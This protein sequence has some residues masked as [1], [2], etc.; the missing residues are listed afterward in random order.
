[1]KF[2]P[3][4]KDS[5][6]VNDLLDKIQPSTPPPHPPRCPVIHLLCFL[7]QITAE[8]PFT[9]VTWVLTALWTPCLGWMNFVWIPS[10]EPVLKCYLLIRNR[11]CN[12][13]LMYLA[14]LRF[15]LNCNEQRGWND[16]SSEKAREERRKTEEEGGEGG[17]DRWR[18]EERLEWAVV[19]SFC[20][21]NCISSGKELIWLTACFMSFS[22]LSA[23]T[24]MY[25]CTLWDFFCLQRKGKYSI[26]DSSHL[27]MKNLILLDFCLKWILSRLFIYVRL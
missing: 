16:G 3:L 22:P 18:E 20:K 27:R 8:G 12:Y 4:R 23:R 26:N 2:L 15:W 19:G 17:R 9:R 5:A 1:M 6:Q 21:S 10:E 24:E 11:H 25:I 14:E 7:R 13:S